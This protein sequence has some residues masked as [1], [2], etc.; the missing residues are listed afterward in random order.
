[1]EVTGNIEVELWTSSSA[2]DTDFTAKLIDVHPPNKDYPNGLS[3]ILSDGI[4]RARFHSSWVEPAL[5]VPHKIYL[6]KIVLNQTSNLFK[7]GHQIRLD[8]SSSNYPKY[9]INPN[10]GEPLGMS[11]T[12]EIANNTIY[13]NKEHQ[14]RIILPMIK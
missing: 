3:M 8:I 11:R 2:V 6:F 1:M 12:I 7:N 10:S 4:I 5:M 9:D 13:Y 14:S